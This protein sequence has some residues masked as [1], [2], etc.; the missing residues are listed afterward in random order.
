MPGAR[1]LLTGA[2]AC[3]ALAAVTPETARAQV[4]RDAGLGKVAPAYEPA[5]FRPRRARTRIRVMP[6]FPYRLYS[7]DY[8]VPYPY[9]APGPGAV[10]QCRSWLASEN[11][12]SGNVIMP[13]MRCWWEHQ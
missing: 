10:R 12:A 11:R 5:Q 1:A 9:E 13:R 2:F 4:M 6:T 7:T 3:L 8:P